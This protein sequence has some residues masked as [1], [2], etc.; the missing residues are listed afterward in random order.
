MKSRSGSVAG[1]VAALLA[2]CMGASAA[3]AES[4]FE[5]TPFAAAVAGGSFESAVDGSDIDIG[6]SG[7]YGVTFDLGAPGFDRHYQLYYSRQDTELDGRAGSVDVEVEYLHVGGILDFPQERF[8]PYVVGTLGATR[9]SA[10]GPDYDDETRFSLALGGGFKFPL[11]EH[12]A[13]RIEGRGLLT[14]VESE[15]VFFCESV[16]GDAGCLIQTSGNTLLQ[17]EALAG[18]TLRF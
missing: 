1:R 16:G 2:L 17:F 8:V 7:A 12:L 14:F 15:S 6:S 11:S 3:A 4:S 13:V 10:Q 9:F 5:L 18:I